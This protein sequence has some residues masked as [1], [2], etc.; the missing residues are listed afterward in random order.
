MR[1]CPATGFCPC[2]CAH[3]RASNSG[4]GV[5]LMV[6][7][8]SSTGGGRSSAPRAAQRPP[9]PA[10]PNARGRERQLQQVQH[11]R[12]LAE[13]NDLL[14]GAAAPALRHAGGRHGAARGSRGGATRM[15]AHAHMHAHVRTHTQN[16]HARTHARMSA[17]LGAH[18][19]PQAPRGRSG[20]G[21]GR[22]QRLEHAGQLGADL[23]AGDG[24]VGAAAGGGSTQPQARDGSET[25]RSR[26]LAELGGI[27]ASCR[28]SVTMEYAGPCAHL[29]SAAAVLGGASPPALRAATSCST[30]ISRSTLAEL[31]QGTSAAGA[32]GAAGAPRAPAHARGVGAGG[33]RSEH[34]TLLDGA[35]AL[36]VLWHTASHTAAPPRMCGCPCTRTKPAPFCLPPFGAGP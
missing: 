26:E 25:M 3:A 16:T 32:A 2:T 11:A 35:R 31:T 27:R 17:H 7:A 18:A 34:H 29:G 10:E 21:R 15:H 14:L 5:R 20:R 6:G 12:P 13:H 30:A 8:G 23:A 33:Q 1:V 22:A 9:S 4:G 24:G 19:R 36:H 28:P